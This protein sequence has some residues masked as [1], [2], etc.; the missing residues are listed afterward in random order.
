MKIRDASGCRLVRITN[1]PVAGLLALLQRTPLV[2]LGESAGEFVLASPMSA[3]LRTAA[4]AA[5]SLGAMHSMAGATALA[6]SDKNGPVTSPFQATVGTPI[7]TLVFTITGTTT[8]GAP[9][10][11]TVTGTMPPGLNFDGLT[12]PGNDNNASVPTTMTGTPT[13][14]G[15]YTFTLTGYENTDTTSGNTSSTTSSP[16]SFTIDVTASA[17]QAP[18]F[19]SN[20]Q[21]Q[22]VTAGQTATFSASA[23]GAPT[24]AWQFNDNPI[25]DGGNISGATTDS[26]T[27]SNASSANAGSYSCVATNTGG[28]T[29]SAAA[30]LA[31]NPA[32]TGPPVFSVQ[33][34]GETI[35][36][37]STVVLTGAAPGAAAYQWQFNGNPL[38]DSP[39]GTASDA[40]S[41][42]TG[43]QLVISGTTAASQGSYIL[44]AT[45]ADGST[46][47]NTASL[48]V[49]SSPNPGFLVNIS[50]RAF[51]G[52]GD[53]ILIGGF[54]IGGSTSRSVLI[55]AL[56][57]ALA[58]QGVL[59]TLPNPVLTIHNSSGA[60]I[61]SNAGWGNS[62]V[63]LKA[64]ASAFAHPVLEPDSADS[65][66]LLTLPPGGYTAEV[67]DA[68]N[69][70]GVALC[71]IYQLP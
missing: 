54:F 50:A 12:G 65:E 33:P 13:Q 4:V 60:T 64:A 42:S 35:N 2:Q 15:D 37:G 53:S 31:V 30:T 22:T 36:N 55:Q 10:S 62:A 34:V 51:V 56:G 40:I 61:Y 23:S 24:Y 8:G 70:T 71:A 49:V 39:A 14:A 69:G 16:F 21:S 28:S 11:W 57:P 63:L 6:V 18:S 46:S 45:N 32:V 59:G 20:P 48:V 19:T 68:G 26:L 38:S 7:P 67:A 47:S 66:V 29:T 44:V 3:T 1:L 43:P 27:I 9:Q 58:G 52:T 41:G 17:V 5:G 25:T